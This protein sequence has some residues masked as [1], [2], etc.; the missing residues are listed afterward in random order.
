MRTLLLL[1]WHCYRYGFDRH[2]SL[3]EELFMQRACSEKL[4]TAAK[5]IS[6]PKDKQKRV[7][8]GN[9]NG[10]ICEVG[11]YCHYAERDGVCAC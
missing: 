3:C 9:G 5:N 7:E 1:F 11:P 6:A 2:V 10:L 8:L 4:E